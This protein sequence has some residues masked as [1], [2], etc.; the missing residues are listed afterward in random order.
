M[1]ET[2]YNKYDDQFRTKS[3]DVHKEK[4]I[5]PLS[6]MSVSKKTHSSKNQP[7]NN[8]P[9]QKSV[10]FTLPTR[11][12]KGHRYHRA[13]NGNSSRAV[14][15]ETQI[16]TAS[17]DGATHCPLLENLDD[18]KN[19]LLSKRQD[20]AACSSRLPTCFN[21]ATHRPLLAKLDGATV[22]LKRT[23]SH[24]SHILYKIL[25]FLLLN[26]Y[27]NSKYTPKQSMTNPQIPIIQLQ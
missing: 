10:S 11:G 25:N 14:L 15:M 3:R 5:I 20:G 9:A 26:F 17:R 19:S 18:P 1:L 21:G 12:H 2:I 6:K 7:Y 22:L 4:F 16:F 13:T 23:F 24:K 8:Q 27:K